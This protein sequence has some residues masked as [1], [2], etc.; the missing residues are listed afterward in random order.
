MQ[1]KNGYD[2]QMITDLIDII[3]GDYHHLAMFL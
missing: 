2:I 3:Y 1:N